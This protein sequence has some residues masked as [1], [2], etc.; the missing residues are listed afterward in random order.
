MSLPSATPI[1]A[2]FSLLV[3]LT[4]LIPVPFVDGYVA[5]KIRKRLVRELA[6][7][8]GKT[9]DDATV[10][11]LADPGE[12]ATFGEQLRGAGVKL[13]WL[14]VKLIA[15]KV[16]IVF[17]IADVANGSAAAFVEGH[18]VDV[19]LARNYLGRRDAKT[20][21][22]AIARA[23]FEEGTHPVALAARKA[24]RDLRRNW[25]SLRARLTALFAH[26][27]LPKEDPE[28]AAAAGH[29]EAI[30]D[31]DYFTKLEAKFAKLL[32]FDADV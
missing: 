13:L 10:A 5:R 17:T 31:R 12:P 2:P 29:F 3:G 24:A 28:V 27:N 30:D 18:L 20:V 11:L 25:P 1:L 21:A 6:E 8:R 4:P 16:L 32:N 7:R 15:R 19:A 26:D 9:L 23:R 14:P 22:A